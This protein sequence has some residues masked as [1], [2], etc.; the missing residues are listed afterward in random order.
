MK[1]FFLWHHIYLAMNSL[2]IR[3]ASVRDVPFIV[4]IRLGALTEEENRGFF[5]PEFA[6]IFSTEKMREVGG[7]GNRL[8]DGFEV[9]LVE[10]EGRLVGYMMLKVDGDYGYIDNI[11]VAK[12]EQRK[13][14]GRTLVAYAEVLAKSKGCH[15]MKTETT[16]NAYG[17]SWKPYGFWKK[18]GMRRY[19]RAISYSLRF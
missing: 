12:E 7:S 8:K 16:E 11:V 13:G 3:A 6:I 1:K 19:W 5:S 17:I 18:N 9:F 14:V 15:L 2:A 4:E 10:D